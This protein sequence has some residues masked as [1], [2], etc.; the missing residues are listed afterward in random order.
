MSY[1]RGVVGYH[2]SLSTLKVSGSSLGDAFCSIILKVPL[3]FSFC[4]AN[5]FL[6][7]LI[8][9]RNFTG[10]QLIGKSIPTGRAEQ[11]YVCWGGGDCHLNRETV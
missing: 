10:E 8:C 7:L 6:S 1:C 4:F 11:R 2:E 9:N 5:F 3:I